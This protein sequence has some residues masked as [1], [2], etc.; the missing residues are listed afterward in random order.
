[1]SALT[2]PSREQAGQMDPR[3]ITEEPPSQ[4]SMELKPLPNHLK[5]AYLDTPSHY[6][7][8]LPLGARIEVAESP[9]A[10]QKSNWVETFKPS[11]H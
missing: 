7:Q 9:K 3:P 2:M 8:Q 1:M 6:R 11:K 10:A 4:P 5:Y